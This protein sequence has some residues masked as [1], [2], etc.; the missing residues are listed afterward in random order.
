M[1]RCIRLPQWIWPGRAVTLFVLA[2]APV[3]VS[4]A[5]T[6]P[7]SA[8]AA[9][10]PNRYVQVPSTT[11]T[12]ELA[13]PPSPPKPAQAVRGQV[14]VRFRPTV[15]R[16]QQQA[17][18]RPWAQAVEYVRRDSPRALQLHANPANASV[19]DQ[20]ALVKLNPTADLNCG[21]CRL[22]QPSRRSLCR[23]ELPAADRRHPA[24][25]QDSG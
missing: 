8:P 20:L 7:L 11:P 19:F 14:L 24:F 13:N 10:K 12:D 17:D 4:G 1:R 23:T 3:L 21:P 5:A 2:L 25:G 6:G 9:P 15:A 18:L 22:A 16:L